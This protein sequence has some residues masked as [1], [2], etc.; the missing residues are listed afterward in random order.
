MPTTVSF[1]PRLALAAVALTFAAA[2]PATTALM[3]AAA[4][5]SAAASKPAIA[6]RK[7]SKGTIL[8]DSRG[9]TI[10]GFTLD[11]RNKDACIAIFECLSLWPAV[12]TSGKV[13]AGH[14]VKRSLIGT[15]AFRGAKKQITYAGHPLYTY[16]QDTKPAQTSNINIF[17]FGGKWPG[18]DAAGKLVK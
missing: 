14:G 10:Y 11:K 1:R 17:Q 9:Y 13:T 18:L 7:T 15:I 16:A 4:P 2:V 8:V 6:L 5:P 12:T 3:L